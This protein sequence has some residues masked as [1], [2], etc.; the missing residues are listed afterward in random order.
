MTIL[1]KFLDQ[2][3]EGLAKE[4]DELFAYDLLVVTAE[5]GTQETYILLD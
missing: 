1:K 4:I 5:D 2:R 3:A